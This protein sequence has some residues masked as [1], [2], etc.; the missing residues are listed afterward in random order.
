M[1]GSFSSKV[2]RALIPLAAVGLIAVLAAAPVSSASSASTPS[3]GSGGKGKL[4]TRLTALSQGVPT[5]SDAI[6][7]NQPGGLS[8]SANGDVLADVL[9]TS[10]SPAAYSQLGAAGAQVTD[11]SAPSNALPDMQNPGGHLYT[12]TATIAPSKLQSVAALDV[13]R[14]VTEDLVPY[15]AV[16]AVTSEGDADLKAANARTAYGV[17]GTGVTVGVLSDSYDTNPA[18]AAT[19][20]TQDVAS[21]DLPGT[22]NPLGHTT[23]V[24]VIDDSQPGKDEGRAMLQTVA[25]MA[26]GA[27]LAFAT[28]DGGQTSFA[29]NI[30]ALKNAGAKVIVDDVIYN[31]EPMYQDGPIAVAVN[32]VRGAGVAYFSMAFNN[33]IILGGKNVASYEQT[34][35]RATSCPTNVSGIDC[36]NF[37]P[38]G[39]PAD[40]TYGMTLANGGKLSLDLQWAQPWGGVTTDYDIYVLDSSGNVLASQTNNNITN[41]VPNENINYTNN[42]GSAQA[43]TVVVSRFAGPG[44][45][46]KWVHFQNGGNPFTSMEYTSSAGTDVIGP[47]IFGHNGAA[48]AYTVGAVPQN[49]LSV[50]EN[51]TSHGPVTLLFQPV[52]STTALGSPQVL[53]KPDFAAVD[54]VT[55]T[56]FPPGGS[57]PHQFC[58]T[59]DAAPHAAGVAALLLQ[60]KSSATAAQIGAALVASAIPVGSP[61][62]TP[63]VV[64]AGLIQATTAINKLLQ[65]VSLTCTVT[66]TGNIAALSISNPGGVLCI[67]AANVNG[68]VTVSNGASVVITNSKIYG[69]LVGTN[70]SQVKVCGTSIAQPTTGDAVN[71]TGTTVATIIGDPLDGCA[72]D[73]LLSPVTLNGNAGLLILGGARVV[74]QGITQLTVNVN[75]NTGFPIVRGNQIYGALNCSGNTKA[76]VNGGTKNQVTPTV[77][78]QCIGL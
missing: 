49:N 34:S 5:P 30:V 67:N 56:F 8:R 68:N 18:G 57:S 77:T 21:G 61:P 48:N 17:D 60:A 63:D 20:A 25:D 74:G 41:Q 33:N 6:P 35:Y 24:N 22:G 36:A 55:N 53:S 11:V 23:P 46:F 15:K 39:G 16:G 31:A 65:P 59:S 40:N 76:P 66:A 69:G 47:T 44:V 28:A 71:I 58:G 12:V 37:N 72:A 29:N 27:S 50:P 75:N 2:R 32:T 10:N 62:A 54:C 42:T 14:A 9:M 13:V 7:D 45:R 1:R 64:G 38:N 19:N 26:P 3:A 52:P 78:G 4:S 51:Y 73:S 43:L 70:A